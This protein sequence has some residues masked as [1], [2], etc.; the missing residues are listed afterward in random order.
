MS[1]DCADVPKRRAV[2][3][4]SLQI[5]LFDVFLHLFCRDAFDLLQCLLAQLETPFQFWG[6]TTIFGKDSKFDD[7]MISFATPNV[8]F[9]TFPRNLK[10][11]II[12]PRGVDVLHVLVMGIN[13]YHLG[14]HVP[15]GKSMSTAGGHE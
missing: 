10:L 3:R 6:P 15:T 12:V 4:S 8:K 1:C 14:H 5:V 7:N 13:L 11:K 2:L 9:K